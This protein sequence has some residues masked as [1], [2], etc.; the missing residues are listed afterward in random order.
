MT[1]EDARTRFREWTHETS[2]K[3]CP[4]QRIDELIWG[5]LQALNRRVH[6]YIKDDA[7]TIALVAATG[8][9]SWAA[10]WIRPLW[11]E[12][13]SGSGQILKKTSMDE[14]RR[15]SVRWRAEAGGAPEEWYAYG[16]KL[17]FFRAPDA[18]AVASSSVVNVRVEAD[19]PPFRT[20]GFSLLGSEDHQLPVYHACGEWL[21]FHGSGFEQ[22]MRA[23]WYFSKFENEA[24]AAAAAY[25]DRE[26]TP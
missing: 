23:E 8:E 6:Y 14:L 1:P 18:A 16:R 20:H 12:W 4:D 21:R 9:Y 3:V 7:A 26:V 22:S 10:D 11:V 17:G 13:P 19:P 2:I 25:A 15:L 5:G 24:K